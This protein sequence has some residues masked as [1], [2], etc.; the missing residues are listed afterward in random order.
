MATEGAA[1]LRRV[2]SDTD[3]SWDGGVQHLPKGTIIAVEP[4]STLEAYIGAGNLETLDEAAIAALP[5]HAGV[6]N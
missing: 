2:I 4:S 5:L 3:F 6:S 1:T